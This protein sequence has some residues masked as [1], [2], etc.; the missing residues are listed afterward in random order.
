M[1]KNLVIVESPT[2]AKTISR[3]LG[4]DYTVTSSFGHVRDLPKSKLGVD[5]D[6]DFAPDYVIPSKAKPVIAELKAKAKTATTIYFATDEDREGE[7]ISWH[8][9]E[10]LKPPADKVKRIA[11]HEITAEAIAEALANPRAID[12]RMVKAQEARRILD[13]LYG[14]EVSP[15]LWRKIKPGLSA[16]RVQSVAVRILVE[17]ERERLAFRSASYWDILATLATPAE[18][19]FSAE[20]TRINDQPIASSKDFD[21]STGKLKSKTA[22]WLQ[23]DEARQLANELIKQTA[24][25]SDITAKPFI[26]KPY[27]PFTTSTLQQEANRK[28]RYSA[29][30]TMQLA[31]GLYE[32]GYITYMRTDSTLLSQ[33]AISAARGWIEEQYGRDYLPSA[34]RQFSTVS[35]NAQEAHEAIRPAGAS[36]QPLDKVKAEVAEDSYRL[37]ELIW[38]RTIASQM[39]D[40]SGQRLNLIITLG[41]AEF[42]ATGK[43]YIHQGYRRAYVEGSDDPEAELAEQETLLPTVNQGDKLN[44]KELTPKG[45]TT[46]PP[47]R[48]TEAALVKELERRGIGRPSTY[49][50]IIDTI[51]RRDYVVKRGTTLIPTF[52]AFAVTNLL[53][54]YLSSLVD[55]DFSSQMEDSLDAIARGEGDDKT[56]LHDFYF[57]DGRPGLKTTLEH[58]KDTIDP[59]LTSGVT[60]GEH[61]GTPLEVRIGRYGPFIKLGEQ[62]VSLPDALSPDEL[63]LTRAL[64]LLA[65]G[66]RQEEPLGTDPATGQAV[67]FKV[68]RFGPYV[69]LGEKSDDQEAPKPKMASLLK[70]MSPTA[71]TLD[72]ALQLLSLPRALGQHPENHELIVAA[73]GRFGPYIKC[74]SDTRSI[75]GDKSPISI[76]L[77]QAVELLK[78]EKKGRGRRTAT[79]LKELGEH[80]A[81]KV[82]I[83][84]MDGRY[85]P[86]VTDGSTNATVP[87]GTAPETVTLEQ[88]LA[89]LKDR[90][91]K[92]KRPKRRRKST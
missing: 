69:Q 51:E 25:V 3:F 78:Q 10:L 46:E 30:R 84:L 86:Y 43:T 27:A 66:K 42:Q 53:E 6:N 26:E 87:R 70:T 71:I 12:E 45:H 21:P 20:L 85:G 88:A 65:Q 17:R 72:E 92:P 64:E 75:P 56:Y 74:G 73:N 16:G 76:T 32:Q 22:R 18:E 44:V 63:T 28:L 89:L 23:E 60:I 24:V 82:K 41:P 62:T 9:R 8:L 2:K 54:T 14:Y 4:T 19:S 67:Y 77:E 40:A 59:R 29:K 79:P 5:V 13:R 34:P 38:K 1:S 33:Q 83:N 36:F 39:T 58:V 91:G 55:Y 57:G 52:T 80:P 35:K 90:E 68:G 61:N 49:A 15:I 11:F 81:T 31:Q 50:S 37:Y 48:L 47:Q 7:A